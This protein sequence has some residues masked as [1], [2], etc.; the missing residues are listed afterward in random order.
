MPSNLKLYDGSTDPDDHITRFC[1][2]TNH[3]NWPMPVWFLMFQQTLDDAARGWFDRLPN[4]TIDSWEAL[5]DQFVSR[6]ALRRKC[7]KAPME[8]TKIVRLANE[9][10]LKFKE[11]GP[12]KPATSLESQS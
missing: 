10:L 9:S 7:I 3:G 1:G 6:F 12:T 11:R 4:G 2:A 5:R 8:I